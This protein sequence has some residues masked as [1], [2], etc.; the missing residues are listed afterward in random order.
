MIPKEVVDSIVESAQVEDVVGEFVNLKKRGTNY[1]GLCPFH[2]EK[3]PSFTV[4]PVKGIYKCFGCGKAGDSVKFLMEHEHY[5][6][7]ESLRYLAKK[8]GIEVP[9]QEISPEYQAEQNRKE[10]I[11]IVL[12]FAEEYYQKQLMESDKGKTV[13]L[14]YLDERE[15]SE[16]S[17]EDFKLGF[18]LESWDAF[19]KH[20]VDKG[21]KE[22]YLVEAGLSIKRDNGNLIDR[23][24]ARIMFP[25]HS[26]SGRTIGFGGRILKQKDKKE[27]KYINSPDTE[28]YNKS[29]V[30]YGLFQGKRAIKGEDVCYLVEGY[31]DVISMHQSGVQNVVASSG[32]SLTEGQLRLVKRYTQNICFIF[33]GDAAGIKASLRAID[34]AL[35]EGLN[36]RALALP[37]G[38]DPDSFSKARSTNEIKAFLEDNVKDFII[39]KT[40]LLLPGTEND[41]I[42]KAEV[43]SQIVHSIALIPDTLKRTVYIQQCAT[44]LKMDETVLVAELN[45]QLPKVLKKMEKQ[46]KSERRSATPTS[47]PPPSP[48]PGSSSEPPPGYDEMP[49]EAFPGYEAEMGDTAA[50]PQEMTSEIDLMSHHEEQLVKFILHFGHLMYDEEHVE[51]VAEHI[52]EFVEE[53]DAHPDNALLVVLLKEYEHHLHHWGAAEMREFLHH[54]NEEVRD[55]AIA[56]MQEKYEASEHWVKKIGFIVK[57]EENYKDTLRRTINRYKLSR[58]GKMVE[59]TMEDIKSGRPEDLEVNLR[60]FQRM[61]QVRKEIADKL[62]VVIF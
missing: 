18:A 57:P 42:K 4:S 22:E 7:P 44:L 54:E 30:L 2:Q 62:G 43:I 24:R 36:V 1:L 9:E 61:M 37:E 55:M 20:A 15:I 6:Y 46:W 39:F 5:S 14:P 12:K 31:T 17:R 48:G 56:L 59:E 52:L 27:A 19:S 10:S 21:Y 60:T 35:E 13:A 41:P 16:G 26:L 29:E 47:I 50:P 34:L 53:Y 8:Y 23:F 3:T 38:E 45:K 25:I 28:V 11:Y 32:T 33:D 40:N 51:T 58:I 49:L